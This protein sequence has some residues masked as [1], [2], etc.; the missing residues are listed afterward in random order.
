MVQIGTRER[1]QMVERVF[2][3][4]SIEGGTEISLTDH[5]EQQLSGIRLH[6]LPKSY[7]SLL[8]KQ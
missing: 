2:L 3:H 5:R 8:K 4:L 7:V 1:K 6:L